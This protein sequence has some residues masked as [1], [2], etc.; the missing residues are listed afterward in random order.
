M[1]P[2]PYTAPFNSAHTRARIVKILLIV[3]A[4]ATAFSL[5]SE[6]V[7]LA[8]PPLGDDQELGDN[9]FGA[10]VML[11]VFLFALLELVIYVTTVVFFCVWLYRAADNL[12]ALNP[13][14]QPE[15]SPGWAVG[16]FFVPFANLIIPYRAVREVW[17]KSSPPNEFLLAEPG[18]PTYFP[19]WWLFWLLA[20]FAGNV[21]LRLSFNEHIDVQ[22]ATIISIVAS[23]LSIVAA[24][25]AY[26]VVDAIDKKQEE[27]SAKVNLGKF[28]GPPPPPDYQPFVQNSF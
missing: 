10:A 19:T 9:P 26:L 28:S 15:Y 16:S 4:I 17:Q 23:A 24:V 13:A 8:V 7:S 21:S 2:S 25:F 14:N 22:T 20:G 3:G 6:A 12:R 5:L 18:P 1:N 11:I 27:T